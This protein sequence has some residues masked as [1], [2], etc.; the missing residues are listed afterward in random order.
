LDREDAGKLDEAKETWNE[1]ANYKNA[2]DV[3]E[4]AWHLLAAKY[5]DQVSAVRKDHKK[6]EETAASDLAAAQDSKSRP[7]KIAKEKPEQ[8]EK[9]GRGESSDEALALLAVKSE[10]TK[11]A[12]AH[13][14]WEELKKQTA[15][16]SGRRRWHLLAAWRCRETAVKPRANP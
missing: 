3:D 16:D 2:D 10:L 4:H 14:Q 8:Q 15:D 5:L 7:P 12:S 6:L 11:N 9:A 1:L 13:E